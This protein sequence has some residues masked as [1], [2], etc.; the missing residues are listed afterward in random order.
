MKNHT[1]KIATGV[2][3]LVVASAHLIR[4]ISV[5]EMTINGWVVPQAISWVALLVTGYFA[6]WAFKKK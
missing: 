1:Y 5:W 3:F 4:A 6:F 2:L